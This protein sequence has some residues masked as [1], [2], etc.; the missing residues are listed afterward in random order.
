MNLGSIHERTHLAPDAVVLPQMYECHCMDVLTSVLTTTNESAPGRLASGELEKLCAKVT[1]FLE[2][3][4][5]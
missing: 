3:R 1:I 5:A 2:L 4:P